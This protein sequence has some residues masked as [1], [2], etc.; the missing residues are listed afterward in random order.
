MA[1]IISNAEAAK[2]DRAS[3]NRWAYNALD[4]C[5]MHGIWEELDSLMDE[6][7]RR[8]YGA[9]LGLQAPCMAVELRG[10]N[11]DHD[12]ARWFIHV[13][14]R[15]VER[16]ERIMHEYAERVPSWHDH[17]KR[18]QYGLNPRSPD[19]VKAFFYEACGIP[20]IKN[21]E[22][23]VSTDLKTLEKIR[24]R[25]YRKSAYPEEARQVAR[26]ILQARDFGKQQDQPKAH[27]KNDRAHFKLSVGQT[28]TFRLSSSK[29]NLGKGTNAQNVTGKMR[30][31][32]LPDP[33]MKLCYIDLEQAE[34]NFLA[35]V[36]GDEA[37]IEAHVNPDVDTHTMVAKMCWPEANWAGDNAGSKDR[38]VAEAPGFYRH[39]SMRD[40]SKK[41]QHAIGRGGTK[42]TV[43]RD[44]GIPQKDAKA[45]IDRFAEGF[46]EVFNFMDW[47]H[48][49][50]KRTGEVIVPGYNVRRQFFDRVWETSVWR[51]ALAFICQAPV[52]WNCHM[53][54]WRIYQDLDGKSLE[55]GADPLQ[56]L[57]HAHDAAMFQY[58]KDRPDLVR[59]AA[60]KMMVPVDIAD[61]KGNVRRMTIGVE[62]AVGDNWRDLDDPDF[63]YPTTE[64][65]L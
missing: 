32:F 17:D 54:F 12:L 43:G 39:F 45:I 13:R 65:D 26:C 5:T 7:A 22:G 47:L 41:V 40:L 57:L 30:R 4:C 60:R 36:S 31:L 27:V 61:Y 25:A 9:Q 35:H 34:S 20:P 49:E 29:D 63:D 55:P 50:L 62:A 19:Q 52:A 8:T 21:K 53:G 64:E 38:A 59:D 33:G 44:L 23:K 37:Y 6:R 16:T 58:Q 24:D 28:E 14:Q 1:K 18:K 48:E 46:P 10:I 3:N 56:V 42:V 2:Y 11:F 15:A 51:D